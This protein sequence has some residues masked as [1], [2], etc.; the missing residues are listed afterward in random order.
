MR[1]REF[2]LV[3]GQHERSEG[4]W[5]CWGETHRG[6]KVVSGITRTSPLPPPTGALHNKNAALI[7]PI[8]PPPLSIAEPKSRPFAPPLPNP[9]DQLRAIE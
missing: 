7:E 8:I 9:F 4:R 1:E 3:M 5:I 2:A 6:R